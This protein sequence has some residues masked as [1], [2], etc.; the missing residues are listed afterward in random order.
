MVRPMAKTLEK[1]PSP[2]RCRRGTHSSRTSAPTATD[3]VPMLHPVRWAS[4][5]WNTSHGSSPSPARTRNAE[6]APYSARPA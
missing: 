4:P 3:T 2:G 6:L 5:W 1:V